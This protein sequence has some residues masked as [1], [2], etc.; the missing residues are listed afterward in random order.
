MSHLRERRAGNMREKVNI[1]VNAL[2]F[3]VSEFRHLAFTLPVC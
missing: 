3:Y 1:S 2:L